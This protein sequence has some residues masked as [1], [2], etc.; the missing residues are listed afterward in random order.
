GHDL[1]ASRSLS[2]DLD[3]MDMEM[4]EHHH[5]ETVAHS[6]LSALQAQQDH[7]EEQLGRPEPS[8]YPCYVSAAPCGSGIKFT[9]PSPDQLKFLGS[10]APLPP[11]V[12]VA[13]PHAPAAPRTSINRCTEPP[14]PPPKLSFLS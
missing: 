12:V 7:A 4:E 14:D 1:H 6:E 10:S 13:T 3:D 2:F 8:R 9:S 11:P 5:S